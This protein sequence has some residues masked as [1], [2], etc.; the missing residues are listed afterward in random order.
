MPFA[1]SFRDA[2]TDNYCKHSEQYSCLIGRGEL[3][4]KI[5]FNDILLF[6]NEE[7]FNTWANNCRLTDPQLIADQEIWETAHGITITYEYYSLSSIIGPDPI[8]SFSTKSPR[9]GLFNESKF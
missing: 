4:K 6:D 7:E 9:T 5:I 1:P 3:D 8:M 2:W